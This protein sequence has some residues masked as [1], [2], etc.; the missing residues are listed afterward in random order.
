MLATGQTVSPG[1]SWGKPELALIAS[2][3]LHAMLY[4]TYV[5]LAARAGAVFA[6][7]SS[8]VVTLAGICWAM[9]LLGERFSPTVWLAAG[10]MLTGIALVRPRPRAQV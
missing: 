6:A 10:V 2:S 9:L 3:S 5:G 7:Q 8:Y 1:G 4:S